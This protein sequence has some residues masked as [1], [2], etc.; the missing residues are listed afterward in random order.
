MDVEKMQNMSEDD[1]IDALLGVGDI[2]TKTVVMERFGIPVKLQ[3]LTGKQV[4]QIRKDNTHKVK[5]KGTKLEEDKLDSENFNVGLIEKATISPKW[6]NEKL[7]DKFRAS[8]GKEVMKRLL[9]AGELDSLA[10]QVLDLSGYNDGVEEI[11]D[12]KNSSSP[13]TDLT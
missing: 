13:D 7:L 1:V 3:A 10:D 6:S 2:P 5:I 9:L 8:D 11:E 12:I 4:S